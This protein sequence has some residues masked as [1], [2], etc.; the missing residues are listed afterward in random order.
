MLAEIINK[1]E[2]FS[3]AL[4][5]G[6]EYH[7]N[8]ATRTL[9]V[10]I[11]CMNNMN[12]HQF[13]TIKLIFTDVKLVQFFEV[14]NQSSTLINAALIADNNGIITFDFF[15]LI[16]AGSELFENENSDFKIKCKNVSY[17]Q[18]EQPK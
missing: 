16:Y 15:P 14:E 17:T 18:I 3:D 10:V 9:E 12:G 5:I 8:D 6:I 4:I 7:P 2:K 1:Y 11:R 13:E